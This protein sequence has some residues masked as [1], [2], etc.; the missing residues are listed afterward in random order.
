MLKHAAAALAL[1]AGLFAAQMAHAHRNPSGLPSPRLFQVS[2]AGGKAGSTV[3]MIVAGRHL[4]EGQKLVFSNPAVKAE[5][6]PAPKPEIDPKTKKPKPVPNALPADHFKYKITIP[7][8]AP[9]GN[10]DV[11][12]VNKWGVSNPRTFVV[13]DLAETAEVE[14][15]NDTDKAQKVAVN[16]TV[17]GSFSSGTDVDYYVFSAKKGQRIVLACR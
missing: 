4:E 17:N 11:R 6:V 7:A 15:N 16:T 1:A 14:P 9:V 2:P 12:L 13:G 8:D 3:E 10:L 5:A